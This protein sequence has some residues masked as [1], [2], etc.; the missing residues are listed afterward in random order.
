MYYTFL[1][2]FLILSLAGSQEQSND[3]NFELHVV[4]YEEFEAFVNA[5][6][7]VTDAEKYG[8]HLFSKMSTNSRS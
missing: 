8:C 5:T 1:S 3:E 2:Y 7:Y 6:G 4:S